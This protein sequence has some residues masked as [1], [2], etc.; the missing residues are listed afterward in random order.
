M[1]QTIATDAPF[2]VSAPVETAPAEPAEVEAPAAVVDDREGTWEPV[3]VPR[4]TYTMKAR[5]GARPVVEDAPAQ[6]TPQV[7][8]AIDDDVVAPQRAVGS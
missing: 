6:D 5:A 7:L 3:P 8:D 4:P 2:D 1:S